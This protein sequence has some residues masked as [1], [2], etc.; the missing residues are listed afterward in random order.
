MDELYSSSTCPKRDGIAA[1][2]KFSLP[3]VANGNVYVTAEQLTCNGSSCTNDG[4]GTF[5]IF[6]SNAKSCPQ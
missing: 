2:T 3:T 4:T 6:G 1:A 5:Y